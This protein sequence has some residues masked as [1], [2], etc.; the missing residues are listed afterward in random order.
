[1]CFLYN[2][3]CKNVYDGQAFQYHNM[4]LCLFYKNKNLQL[5][6]QEKHS[7][8]KQIAEGLCYLHSLG[9]AHRDFKCE[10]ILM[11]KDKTPKIADF[12]LS[13]NLEVS[14]SGTQTV[15]GTPL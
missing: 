1:M 7:I 12:G 11:T 8:I 14:G 15:C 2:F 6:N 4:F 10:N 13:K 5:N 9:I 3:H